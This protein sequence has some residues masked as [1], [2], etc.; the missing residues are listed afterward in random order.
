MLIVVQE[1]RGKSLVLI[2]RIVVQIF[3]G[4][5]M[6]R[7]VKPVL[8]GI[9]L[10]A[11]AIGSLGQAT[12]RGAHGSLVVMMK[13]G[14]RET[15]PIADISKVE[16]KDG[17]I[18]V[19]RERGQKSF[20]L[21]ETRS[22]EFDTSASTAFAPG[23]NHFVGKWRV[24]QGPG[25]RDFY[26]TLETNG[27]AHKTLGAGHGTWAVVDGEARIAWDDGWHDVIRRVGTKHEKVAFEPG[28][29]FSEKPNNVTA[30]VNSSPQ[31]I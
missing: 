1:A 23:R 13:D 10:V 5:N 18:V 17:D 30:A 27:E 25:A 15:I 8:L 19:F 24:G 12:S 28:K 29:S 31:P 9:I 26:I 11:S 22:F 20:R 6:H 16:F 7:I 3:L 2:C 21:S 4:G 14:R